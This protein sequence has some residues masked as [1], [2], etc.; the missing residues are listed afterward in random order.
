MTTQAFTM[1]GDEYRQISVGQK[2]VL[3]NRDFTHYGEMLVAE[4]QPDPSVD[5]DP[6]KPLQRY[7]YDLGA[8][9]AVWGKAKTGTFKVGTTPA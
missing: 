8:G 6:M 7:M 1:V 4:F 2:G 3:V 5:G 9:L